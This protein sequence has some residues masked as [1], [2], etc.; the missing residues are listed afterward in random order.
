MVQGQ[1]QNWPLSAS[2]TRRC[3]GLCVATSFDQPPDKGTIRK[4]DPALP[5]QVWLQKVPQPPWALPLPHA[6]ASDVTHCT[7]GGL[8]LME[9]SSSHQ[10]PSSPGMYNVRVVLL[11][12]LY[13]GLQLVDHLALCEIMTSPLARASRPDL[14]PKLLKR[15]KTN[16]AIGCHHNFLKPRH[17]QHYSMHEIGPLHFTLLNPNGTRSKFNQMPNLMTEIATLYNHRLNGLFVQCDAWARN[18]DLGHKVQQA[19]NHLM[20]ASCGCIYV[21]GVFQQKVRR[22]ACI[23]LKTH[24]SPSQATFVY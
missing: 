11:Q 4:Q 24:A 18:P 17:L 10:F 3:I 16:I 2:P 8:Q 12:S 1:I 23:S 21:I 14:Q 13:D 7:S 5:I 22:A 19:V 9:G 20:C 6:K 15:L